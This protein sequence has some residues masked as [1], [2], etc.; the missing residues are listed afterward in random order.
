VPGAEVT[1]SAQGEATPSAIEASDMTKPPSF[2]KDRGEG[3]RHQ[4]RQ[5]QDHGRD[6]SDQLHPARPRPPNRGQL[7]E[8]TDRHDQA[9]R[10]QGNEFSGRQARTDR[11]DRDPALRAK[12]IKGRE[13]AP[14][15]RDREP[16]PNSPFAKLAKLKEQLEAD[17][18]EP[19]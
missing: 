13:H 10:S 14:A 19:R 2:P 5:R 18:K 12:Y 9:R 11:P 16:D 8:R 7:G 17:A 1:T 6:H 15:Q 3:P 4:R